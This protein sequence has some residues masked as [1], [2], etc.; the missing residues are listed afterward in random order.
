[1]AQTITPAST[2]VTGYSATIQYSPDLLVECVRARNWRKKMTEPLKNARYVDD[3]MRME[4]SHGWPIVQITDLSKP[5]T[6][7]R[8]TVDLEMRIGGTPIPGDTDATGSGQPLVYDRD[9][10]T[11][12][13]QT[14]PIDTGGLMDRQRS[15]HD[16][17]QRGM[18]QAAAWLGDYEDSIVTVALAGARGFDTKFGWAVPLQSDPTF[19]AVMSNN[20]VTPPTLN[21]YL[22]PTGSTDIT[23]VDTTCTMTL[24]F[25][26]LLRTVVNSAD[27]PLHGVAMT[28]DTYNVEDRDLPLWIAFVTEE[29]WNSLVTAVGTQ[30]WRYYI[31]QANSR[32]DFKQHP[33]FY[34]GECALWRNILIR[35]YPRPILF[36]AGSQVPYFASVADANA[37][38]IS[39]FTTPVRLH[40][41]F[42]VGAQAL[43]LAYGDATPI[44]SGKQAA[45]GAG[46]TTQGNPY[47]WVEETFNFG[48]QLKIAA[49]TMIGVKKLRYN[50][51]GTVYD[52]GVFVFDTYQAPIGGI[53]P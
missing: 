14:F 12:N 26:D 10:V 35:V 8:V 52:N 34:D 20:P 7:D 9:Q 19:N 49:S 44:Y 47:S 41:G 22:L 11:V 1:M 46:S 28:D 48:K 29:Q 51:R 31:S 30:N 37:G 25:F 16:L 40:R 36:P 6:G 27:V 42:M 23:T 2:P 39:Y 32:L 24:N 3:G 13:A 15:P 4:S 53:S 21:R 50:H 17:R 38:T 18:L 33:L 5:R 43:G 45:R